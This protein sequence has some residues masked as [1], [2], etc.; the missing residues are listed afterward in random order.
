MDIFTVTTCYPAHFFKHLIPPAFL[1]ENDIAH[2]SQ[3]IIIRYTTVIISLISMLLLCIPTYIYLNFASESKM[4]TSLATV[5][6]AVLE[7]VPLLLTPIQGYLFGAIALTTIADE[8]FSKAE[9]LAWIFNGIV[10]VFYIFGTVIW[11]STTCYQLPIKKGYFGTFTQPYDFIDVII[12]FLI[13]AC[14][15]FLSTQFGKYAIVV[16]V[17]MFFYGCYKLYYSGAQTYTS[18]FGE[19]L[20]IKLK[21]D[22]ILY[23]IFS[24]VSLFFGRGSFVLIPVGF[25]LYFLSLCFSVAFINFYHTN[26]RDGSASVFDIKNT[27]TDASAVAK[28]RY[29]CIHACPEIA[30]ISY[31]NDIAQTR[32]SMQLLVD[33]TRICLVKGINLDEIQIKAPIITPNARSSLYFLAYQVS[34]FQHTFEDDSEPS[35]QALADHLRKSTEKVSDAMKKFWIDLD[36]DHR[37][38]KDM[39]DL[40]GET[41]SEI[42]IALL[43]YPKSKQ[44]KMIGEDYYNNTL[45][46]PVKSQRTPMTTLTLLREPAGTIFSFLNPDSKLVENVDE[47]SPVDKYLNGK[48]YR[49][50]KPL[51][52]ATLSIFILSFIIVLMFAGVS[53]NYFERVCTDTGTAFDLI[54]TTNTLTANFLNAADSLFTQP[55]VARII[56]V[57]AFSESDAGDLRSKFPRPNSIPSLTKWLKNLEHNSLHFNI[58][59]PNCRKVSFILSMHEA[60]IRESDQDTKLCHT[61]TMNENIHRVFPY[62]DTIGLKRYEDFKSNEKMTFIVMISIILFFM[63]V[64]AIVMF[65]F[66]RYKNVVLEAVRRATIFNEHRCEYADSMP[67]RVAF[68]LTYVLSVSFILLYVTRCYFVYLEMSEKTLSAKVQQVVL[69]G[70]IGYLYQEALALLMFYSSKETTDDYAKSIYM[71]IIHQSSKNMSFFTEKVVELAHEYGQVPVFDDNDEKDWLF[72]KIREFAQVIISNITEPDSYPF[73]YARHLA[74]HEL[75]VIQKQV[76]PKMISN[77]WTEIECAPSKFWWSTVVCIVLLSLAMVLM[78]RF[79]SWNKGWMRAANILIRCTAFD[80]NDR[81]KNVIDILENREPN[82]VDDFPFPTV[83]RRNNGAIVACNSKIL[84]FTPHSRAQIIGNNLENFFGEIGNKI[85]VTNKEGKKVTMDVQKFKCGKNHEIVIFK[86]I[87]DLVEAEAKYS[88]LLERL[89]L[90]GIDIP[91][92]GVFYVLR[93]R[94][95]KQ[96]QENDFKTISQLEQEYGIIRISITITSYIAIARQESDIKKLIEFSE[97]VSDIVQDP[98]SVISVIVKGVVSIVPLVGKAIPVLCGPT[99]EKALDTIVNGEFGILHVQEDTLADNEDAKNSVSVMQL[100]LI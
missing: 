54:N 6:Y 58:E 31:L 39:W 33:I 17:M 48:L 63:I 88:K 9:P 21:I 94:F 81:L 82:Y 10:F 25:L 68:P 73:L 100:K 3:K 87:T 7:Y 43:R 92:R 13:A 61:V 34:I 55:S 53:N 44:I 66:W 70:R 60:D 32:S 71:D 18:N 77:L 99:A 59:I 85:T 24:I 38:I 47:D 29:A 27:P 40:I 12:T 23:G 49:A 1:P 83:V 19:I 89:T 75:S 35:V 22:Y 5:A 72:A 8:S 42:S 57:L 78:L 51:L 11:R 30:D 80:D 74:M 20:H 16:L 76:I 91:H 50:L 46:D 96:I 65:N 45:K 37:T 26:G 36:D 64:W 28:V 15:P 86:D 52:I 93:H 69:M 4:K 79:I 56:E 62:L 98:K 2:Y 67:V 95:Q 41:N 14:H 97:K 84:S 90:N